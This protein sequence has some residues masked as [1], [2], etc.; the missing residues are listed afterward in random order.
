MVEKRPHPEGQ[1]PNGD[2]KRAKGSDAI[3]AAR[4]KAQEIAARFAAKKAAANGA[5]ATPAPPAAAAAAAAPSDASAR[6]AAL[7]ARMDAMKSAKEEPK[8]ATPEPARNP[9]AT[10]LGNQ[11]VPTSKVDAKPRA[12]APKPAQA[13]GVEDENPYFDAK[14]FGT[15]RERASRSLMFNEHGKYL[16][17]ASKLRAQTRLEQIKKKL[18]Q[19]ARRAGLDENSERGFMV[20]APPDIEWWDEGILPEKNY[21]CIDDPTKVKID[22]DDSIIT[23]YVQHPPLL[24]APQDQRLVEI[25]PMYLTK[26]EQEKLRRMRRAADLKEHQAKI[27]LGLEPPPPPKV[28]R[29]NMM[30]VMGEQAIAD[31][32]A[33]EML[34][35]SQIAERHENHIAANEDRKLTKEQ[36]HAKLATQQEKDAQK[37]LYLCVFKIN[38]LAY[39]KH[40]YQIDQNGKQYA[41]NGVTIFNPD[42]NL[43]V[44]EGGRFSISKFKKLMLQRIKWQENAP[45]TDTQAEKHASDPQWLK[46]MDD[47]GNLKDLS[48]NK[49]TLVFEGEVKQHLFFKWGSRMCE[50]AGEAREVLAR[51]KLDSLWALAKSME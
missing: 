5:P 30:R 41:L 45:P 35:E 13:Q 19:Q 1:G 48:E 46:S 3:A 2:A 15:G 4:A 22:S 29:G 33:V 6:L 36:Q 18:A 12:A 11:R 25:K 24:K 14:N 27:R 32:T 20:Q 10:T 8:P 31:P 17:Q 49:C 34:V 37:G 50:T 42:M 9:F 23:F 39:S 38:T 16:D 26:K 43:V 51:T 28:K 47:K 44:V 40:R 7:K 21:D